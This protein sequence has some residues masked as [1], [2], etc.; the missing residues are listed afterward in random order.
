[1]LQRLSESTSILGSWRPHLLAK[2]RVQTMWIRPAVRK[3]LQD[4]VDSSWPSMAAQ[5]N[6][7][8]FGICSSIYGDTILSNA[9]KMQYLVCALRGA[10]LEVIDSYAGDSDTYEAAWQHVV[11]QYDDPRRLVTQSMK[12]P[13]PRQRFE[14]GQDNQEISRDLSASIHADEILAKSQ[15]V[16]CGQR[17]WACRRTS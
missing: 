11:K 16:E 7:E 2:L 5:K 6:G 4:S 10:A 3:G 13:N 9:E 15:E 12:R 1:M 8:N 14:G 17:E